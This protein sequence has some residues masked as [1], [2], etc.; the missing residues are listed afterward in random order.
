M[1]LFPSDEHPKVG[2]LGPMVVLVLLRD[3]HTALHTSRAVPMYIP[4]SSA[5]PFLCLASLLF[6]FVRLETDGE[7]ACKQGLESHW[8]HALD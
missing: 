2:L 6:L 3:L 1:F 8:V 7:Q 5:R 4:T